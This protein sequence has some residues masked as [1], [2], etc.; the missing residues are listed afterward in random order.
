MRLRHTV[1][2]PIA[3]AAAILILAASAVAQADAPAPAMPRPLP[4]DVTPCELIAQ[5]DKFNQAEVMAEGLL[6]YGANIF[7]LNSQDCG[8]EHGQIWLEFGGD[9]G[10]PTASTRPQPGTNVKIDGGE[11]YLDKDKKL[12]SLRAMLDQMRATGT[13]K[14]LRVELTGKFFAGKSTK[15]PDGSVRYHGYGRAGCCSLLVIEK[16]ETVG[17]EIEDAVDFAPDAPLTA[18]K[19]AGC[20]TTSLPVPERED[21]DKLQ[22]LG[23]REEYQYLHDPQEVAHRAV[24]P[25]LPTEGGAASGTWQKLQ[26][27]AA[28]KI[29]KWSGA[30]GTSYTV[31]VSRP[32]WLL[33]T[34]HTGDLV[35]W[36][37]TAIGKTVCGSGQR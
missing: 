7:T 15:L 5:P 37:P 32:Y 19:S 13:D 4:F 11:I 9:V 17:T 6:L 33:P 1:L 34:T 16:V 12:D 27:H 29:Y 20:T 28:Q 18:K 14:M 23:F 21:E 35:I 10:D 8:G 36:V 22:R 31:Q 26:D 2:T 24:P 25:A 30:D 3:C